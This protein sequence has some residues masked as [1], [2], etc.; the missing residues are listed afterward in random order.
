MEIATILTIGHSNQPAAEFLNLLK[1]QD[2]QFVIDVRS[3]P[4]SRYRHFNREALKDRLH[5]VGIEY[6]H[7]GDALG[8]HPPEDEFYN[9]QGRVVYERLATLRRFRRAISKIV[10]ESEQYTLALLCVEEDPAECHRHPLLAVALLE[11]G[12]RVLHL[13]RKGSIQDAEGMIEQGSL[14]LP[15]VEPVGEDAKWQSP[16]RIRPRGRP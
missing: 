15:L 6:S 12:L 11:R 1:G 8:G 14:Q 10:E 5:G 4:Y 2:I 16:K 9:D 3:K 13:R 7:R